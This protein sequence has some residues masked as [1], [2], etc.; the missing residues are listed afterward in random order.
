M[1]LSQRDVGIVPNDGEAVHF[2]IS[3]GGLK[4]DAFPAVEGDDGG[5]AGISLVIDP[6]TGRTGRGN[7]E[8][9][10]TGAG[11]RVSAVHG[12]DGVARLG[13]AG[14]VLEG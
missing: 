2:N 7:I 10:A 12:I 13:K 4:E 8:N 6:V 5:L 3:G 9:N 11:V 1:R 14:G